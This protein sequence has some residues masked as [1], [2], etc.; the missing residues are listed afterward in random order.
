MS[1]TIPGIGSIDPAC[2][3]DLIRLEEG[4]DGLYRVGVDGVEQI[5]TPR[6]RKVQFIVYADK[7]LAYVRSAGSGGLSG[8]RDSMVKVFSATTKP[9]LA[10]I[11]WVPEATLAN[12]RLVWKVP[13]ASA[14]TLTSSSL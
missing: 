1:Q 10:V 5:L 12:A 6:D 9:S 2:V 14:I 3:E 11:V 7:T 8:D 13:V 4:G